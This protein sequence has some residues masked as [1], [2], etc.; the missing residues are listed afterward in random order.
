MIARLAIRNLSRNQWRSVLTAGGIA[1]AVGMMIWT[2]SF[3]NG[4]LLAVVQGTT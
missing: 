4:W 2:M 3:L 1:V